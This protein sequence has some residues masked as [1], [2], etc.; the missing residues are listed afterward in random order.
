MFRS[1]VGRYEKR[2]YQIKFVVIIQDKEV[3]TGKCYLHFLL[4]A[5]K[6]N[7]LEQAFDYLQFL[8]HAREFDFRSCRRQIFTAQCRS[9]HHLSK[10]LMIDNMFK[11]Q[12]ELFHLHFYGIHK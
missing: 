5:S 1:I 8:S 11:S 4:T 7:L 6:V 3:I 12:S 2:A 10:A 9:S